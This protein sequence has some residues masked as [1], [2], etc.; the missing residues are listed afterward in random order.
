MWIG[1]YEVL[2]EL[3]RGGTGVVYSA[4]SPEGTAVAV[5]VL[6]ARGEEV[7][8]RFERE[9]RLLSTLGEDLGFVP[10]LDAG[11]SSQ[12]PYIAMPLLPGKTLRQTLEAGPLPIVETIEL[13]CRLAS[14][15]GAAHALGIALESRGPGSRPSRYR[16]RPAPRRS[17]L[18]PGSA[19]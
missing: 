7:L 19:P 3:G 8:A 2:G 1:P 11:R 14:S 6:H 13:G 4:R 5:K 18:F 17:S 9:R 10:L 15:L 16:R 12:G